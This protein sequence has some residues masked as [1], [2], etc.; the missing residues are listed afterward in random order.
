MQHPVQIQTL[1]WYF[2]WQKETKSHLCCTN[3]IWE[4]KGSK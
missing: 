2:D 4:R 1:H 3:H